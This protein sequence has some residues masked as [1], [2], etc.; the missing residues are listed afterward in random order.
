MR[1]STLRRHP[2]APVLRLGTLDDIGRRGDRA[3]A[4]LP[5][6]AREMNALAEEAAESRLYAGIHFRA[7]NNEG[8]ALG[9]RIGAL[10]A[11]QVLGAPLPLHGA[12]TK[13]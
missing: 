5:E 6:R 9:R 4:F 7:D 12:G 1:I 13:P 10:V 2:A 11:G 8:L 3:A